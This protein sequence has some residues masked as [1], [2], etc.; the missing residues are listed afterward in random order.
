MQVTRKLEREGMQCEEKIED[1]G[2]RTGVVLTCGGNHVF[3]GVEW[4][5]FGRS[6]T[7][8]IPCSEGGDL[9]GARAGAIF[10]C[11]TVHS[12]AASRGD[13]RD[14]RGERRRIPALSTSL[15]EARVF[16][17]VGLG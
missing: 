4:A 5:G 9:G 6:G 15:V 11:T 7:P 13:L 3:A 12:A 17:V 2:G 8:V 1:L 10:T 16:C 14:V